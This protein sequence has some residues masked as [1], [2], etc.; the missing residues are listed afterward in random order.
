MFNSFQTSIST[1]R[2]SFIKPILYI[3]LHFLCDIF[4][5][6]ILPLLTA[7]TPPP[8]FICFSLQLNSFVLFCFART[9]SF[10]CL[11]YLEYLDSHFIY[12]ILITFFLSNIYPHFIL[13]TRILLLYPSSS[14][15]YVYL[16]CP[17]YS[18]SPLFVF[19]LIVFLQFKV[20][21]SY[22]FCF[23]LV[24]YPF[25][26]ISLIFIILLNLQESPLTYL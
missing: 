2:I 22:H 9:E 21:F 10:S 24:F 4:N 3:C 26:L 7:L 16:L 11:L 25:F 6:L 17:C 14:I 1:H 20:S 18:F 5:I 23:P 13:F 19:N 12:F 15:F 8:L